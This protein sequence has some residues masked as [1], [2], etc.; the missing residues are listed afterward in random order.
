MRQDGDAQ[1]KLPKAEAAAA[2]LAYLSQV[3]PRER[4]A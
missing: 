3:D 4:D 2:G 1:P